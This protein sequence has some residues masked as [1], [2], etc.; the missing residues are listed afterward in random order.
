MHIY[1]HVSFHHVSSIDIHLWS[2]NMLQLCPSPV[3]TK[4]HNNEGV[5]LGKG[6][7][8]DAIHTFRKFGTLI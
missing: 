8:D 1:V 4:M 3:C 7:A 5:D 6:N 2:C